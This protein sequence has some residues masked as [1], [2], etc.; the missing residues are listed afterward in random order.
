MH[1]PLTHVKRT[2]QVR[3]SQTLLRATQKIQETECTFN[4][5]C[6]RSRRRSNLFMGIRLF[7]ILNYLFFHRNKII[8]LE[9]DVK[10]LIAWLNFSCCIVSPQRVC[11]DRRELPKAGKYV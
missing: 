4:H 11:Y 1:A 5:W 6:G 2:P 10:C 9:E 8:N 7:S 3:K